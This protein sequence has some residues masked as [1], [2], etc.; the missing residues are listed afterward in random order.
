LS[1]AVELRRRH[2]KKR[3]HADPGSWPAFQSKPGEASPPSGGP[4]GVVAVGGGWGCWAAGLL[5]LLFS[6]NIRVL[7]DAHVLAATDVHECRRKLPDFRAS[8]SALLHFGC[9]CIRNSLKTGRCLE[10]RTAAG[11]QQLAR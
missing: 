6:R 11:D 10:N 9:P 2:S 5:G 8:E 3:M 7:K 4:A 1:H